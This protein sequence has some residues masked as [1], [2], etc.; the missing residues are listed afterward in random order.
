M[1]ENKLR[2][3][4]SHHRFQIRLL[5]W[6]MW[7]LTWRFT[8]TLLPSQVTQIINEAKKPCT[9]S[10]E[11]NRREE[12]SRLNNWRPARKPKNTLIRSKP[13][14]KWCSYSNKSSCNNSST[15]LYHRLN[16]Q[17]TKHPKCTKRNLPSTKK[18]PRSTGWNIRNL[19][20]KMVAHSRVWSALEH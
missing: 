20:S 18:A 6:V 9:T 16:K 14:T 8:A 17:T 19:N 13:L 12:L 2:P 15:P 3:R 11:K 4:N 7:K 5:C 1:K 10:L